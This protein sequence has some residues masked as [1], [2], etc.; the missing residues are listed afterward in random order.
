MESL[1]HDVSKMRDEQEP[2]VMFTAATGNVGA[3]DVESV[4]RCASN[5]KSSLAAAR[6]PA[7]GVSDD[8]ADIG[9]HLAVLR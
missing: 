4:A 6:D 9:A 8:D 7:D 3:K 2:D 5:D 1:K